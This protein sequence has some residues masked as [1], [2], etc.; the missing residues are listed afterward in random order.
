M[1]NVKFGFPNW[2]QPTALV[3]PTVTGAGWIDL[4][5]LQ[6]D[7]M[8]EMARYP[9]VNPANTKL[10]LDLGTLRQIDLLALPFHNAKPGDKARMRVATDA[11]FTDVVADS[12]M[13]EFFP[14]LYPYGTLPW[15]SENLL[16]GHLTQEQAAGMIPPWTHFPPDSVLGRYIETALDFSDNSDGFVDL[17]QIVAATAITPRYNVSYGVSVPFPR[18]PSTKTRTKGGVQFVDYVR[19][20]LSTKMQLDWL[21]GDELYGQF[22]EFVR[23]YG[24]SKPFFFIYDADAEPAI[25]TKTCFMAIAQTIG[26]PVRVRLN[27]HSLP[28]EINQTF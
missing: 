23:R 22:Y 24:T 7:V 14:E 26:D 25:L 15:G 1:A 12:G 21:Q 4:S 9:G 27:N 11:A 3:T 16:D 18:D 13:K 17:G 8:S 2:T 5:K 10:V 20:Y 19:T 6:G 28:I